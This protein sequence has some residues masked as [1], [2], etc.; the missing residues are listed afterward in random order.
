MNCPDI[1]VFHIEMGFK[2]RSDMVLRF[3]FFLGQEHFIQ[4]A[5]FE[6]SVADEIVP[7]HVQLTYFIYYKVDK[8]RKRLCL[9]AR[10]IQDV[11]QLKYIS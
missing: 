10:S 6:Y 8:S 2:G 11:I 9:I 5:V 7:H 1:N 4:M 3:I